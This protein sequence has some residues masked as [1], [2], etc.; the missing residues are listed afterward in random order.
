[1]S[2]SDDSLL[3]WLNNAGRF[4]VLSQNEVIRLSRD[5]HE[6]GEDSRKGQRAIKKLVNHNLKLIP[7]ITKRIL[8]PRK[9]F[10]FGDSHTID[11]L[12]AGVF[13]LYR[14]AVLYDYRR[15]YRFSTYAHGWIYQN[16]QR[17][18]YSLTSLIY[19]PEQYH[20]DQKYL[21]D[22]KYMTEKREQ[23][24]QYYERSLMAQNALSPALSLYARISEDEEIE[25]HDLAL[26]TNKLEPIDSIED[27]F[28]L[29]ELEID[30][31]HKDIVVQV[32]CYNA[33]IIDL[34]NK[35]QMNRHEIRT[36][37]NSTLGKLKTAMST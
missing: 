28:N 11:L 22:I 33:R 13:G 4:H 30:P 24:P 32:C 10:K 18:L 12:Q 6:H 14:A 17:H 21:T 29:S 37:M 35:Y 20:R 15:G 1:M 19:V 26:Q 5:I 27:I 34:A 36:I 31:V 25:R 9:L 8:A 16:V 7:I 23:R 2:S 3:F